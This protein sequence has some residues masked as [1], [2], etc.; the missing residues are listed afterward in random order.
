MVVKLFHSINQDITFNT[1]QMWDG[2]L[3]EHHNLITGANNAAYD[4]LSWIRKAANMQIPLVVHLFRPTHP[5]LPRTSGVYH[6]VYVLYLILNHA[7]NE[8]DALRQAALKTLE[9]MRPQGGVG[10]EAFVEGAVKDMKCPYLIIFSNLF[11]HRSQCGIS[12][13]S[14]A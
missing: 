12:L 4:T 8:D 9:E 6:G 2:R 3:S 1:Y 5:H 13:D 14:N 10:G 11:F 7:E